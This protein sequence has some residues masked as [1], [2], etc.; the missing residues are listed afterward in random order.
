MLLGP[1]VCVRVGAKAAT[2]NDG[3]N[4]MSDVPIE[5]G[6]EFRCSCVGV[7]NRGNRLQR[8]LQDAL[9]VARRAKARRLHKAH[10]RLDCRS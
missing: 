2:A 5:R 4:K 6:E 3:K 8:W 1:Q 9:I 10:E 7:I